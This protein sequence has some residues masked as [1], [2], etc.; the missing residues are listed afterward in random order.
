MHFERQTYET[1]YLWPPHHS[2]EALMRD[3][4]NEIDAYVAHC[5]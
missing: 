4:V 2:M 1:G 5:G 3:A